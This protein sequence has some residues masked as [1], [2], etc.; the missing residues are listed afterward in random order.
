MPHIAVSGVVERDID[1][2]L[3][4]ELAAPDGFLAWFLARI[5][6]PADYE[7]T[8]VAH[9]AT[10][11]TGETDIELTL[12]SGDTKVMVLVE[13][14][15]D[16]NLQPRQAERYRDR[17]SRH[18][19]EGQCSVCITVIV[20]P[21]AYFAGEAIDLGFDRVIT[22]ED[23]LGWFEDAESLSTRR[24]LK[25]ALLSRAVNRGG[26]AWKLVPDETATEFWRRYWELCRTIAPELRM[27]RPDAK[28][29]TSAFIFFR[30][31]GLPKSAQLVHKLPYGNVDI[32][33]AGMAG[34]LQ[35]LGQQ[36]GPL[37]E[38]GMTLEA[39]NKSA[40]IRITVPPVEMRAPFAESESAVREGIWA[41][42][43]LNVWA[44][45]AKI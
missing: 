2:I 7:L 39:A 16:A 1:F 14:K 8:S 44:K 41:A 13:N 3:V 6:L 37:F 25:T 35:K 23:L 36:Y 5:G 17:A 4:E 22:Y 45:R 34:E 12:A 21:K 29:A 40:A 26:S 33:L 32:Q 15:I 31:S 42:K 10:T 9:S 11:S 30:P 27:A 28:P 19:K 43:L 18:V 24:L 20:A 38:P